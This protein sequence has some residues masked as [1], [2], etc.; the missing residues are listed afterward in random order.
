VF[1]LIVHYLARKLGEDES[2]EESDGGG[3]AGSTLDWSVNYGH[4]T[5]SNAHAARELASI[6]EQAELLDDEEQYRK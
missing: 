2:D 6:Q 5:A 3:F 1:N 4:G